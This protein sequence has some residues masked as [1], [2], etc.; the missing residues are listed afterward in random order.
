MDFAKLIARVDRVAID[1]FG[2][3]D[4]AG[5]PEP[6]VY[7]PEVG[8]PV[9]VTGIFSEQYIFADGGENSGVEAI[10]P[11]LFCRVEDLPVDL[12][13]DEPTL[14]IRGVDYRVTERMPDGMGGVVL[15]LR[16]IRAV[17]VEQAGLEAGL[18]MPLYG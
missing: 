14:T 4:A 1:V 8:V 3:K 12:E 6:I 17:P 10:G 11:A 7:T 13:D 15:P 16:K 5:E 18:E 2:D 9:D